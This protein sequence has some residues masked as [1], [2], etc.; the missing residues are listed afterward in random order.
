MNMRQSDHVQYHLVRTP[1]V[2][3]GGDIVRKSFLIRLA[4]IVFALALAFGLGGKAV[5]A[6]LIDR[7]WPRQGKSDG[8]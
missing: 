4:G 8:D 2:N 3:V 7:C 1:K 5:A 6:E